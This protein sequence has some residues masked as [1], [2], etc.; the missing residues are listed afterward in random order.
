M[1]EELLINYLLGESSAEEKEAVEQW[2]AL[3]E[4]HEAQLQVLARLLEAGR[5]VQPAQLPDVELAWE[6]FKSQR[7]K[8]LATPIERKLERSMI[9]R[10]AAI[11]LVLL[12]IGWGYERYQHRWMEL[13]AENAIYT[14]RL[15]DGSE[16]TLNKYTHLKFRRNF[17]SNRRIDMEKGDAFFKVARNEK[18]PFLIQLGDMQVKVLGTSFHIHRS[19]QSIRVSVESGLVHVQLNAQQTHLGAG[20]SVEWLLGSASF[21]Q[22]TTKDILDHYYY[23]R[24]FVAD[25]QPLTRVLEVLGKAYD[26]RLY[27]DES[28]QNLHIHTTLKY[29]D[30]SE[31]LQVIRESM[32]GLQVEH[33]GN[34]IKL[35]MK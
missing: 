18:E 30:L 9:L 14:K 16:I 7:S 11:L 31:N 2:R 8:A 5:A 15:A 6:K 32:P 1:K 27:G 12:T 35:S 33:K 3:K 17:A 34:E 28:I 29:G 4:D 23:T 25:N 21:V 20:E 19:E 10:I 26:V 22:E 24:L 13:N